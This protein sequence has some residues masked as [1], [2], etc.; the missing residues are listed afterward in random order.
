MFSQPFFLD[1]VGPA[2]ASRNEGLVGL[3]EKELTQLGKQAPPQ[4]CHV[5]GCWSPQVLGQLP[6]NV[7]IHL[8]IV[9][10]DITHSQTNSTDFIF[11][12]DG[13]GAVW[14]GLFLPTSLLSGKYLVYEKN[15][16][17]VS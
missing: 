14:K 9:S 8:S 5:G 10:S 16:T 17:A 7:I 4:R 2:L 13:A 6:A 11:R 15:K 3:G 12:L 1:L